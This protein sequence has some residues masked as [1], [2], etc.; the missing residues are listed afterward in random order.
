MRAG[1]ASPPTTGPP[2]VSPCRSSPRKCST[3]A[4]PSSRRRCPPSTSTCSS[5]CS[6]SYGY[7]MEVLDNDNR[8][9]IDMGLKYVN[10]DA[11]YPLHHRRRPDHG[12]PFC[13]GSTTRIS[14]PSIMTQ[15]GG[16]C[17]ASNY[18]AFIRR[19]LDKAGLWPHPGH[20]P[21]CQRHGEE[22]G[23]HASPGLLIDARC[24]RSSTATCFM[25]CLYRVRPYEKV[26]GSAERPARK[27]GGNRCIDSLVKQQEPVSV[28]QA[29]LPRDR[30]SISTRFPLDETL[31]KPR[32]GV[33]GEILVKYMPL[34]NNHL[35]DLL[36]ARGGGGR[37]AGPDGLSELLR[38]QRRLQA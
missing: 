36:E 25:R 13:P 15:T 5:R 2:A 4:I 29:R 20:L 34:A 30:G 17:R 18:V 31:R 1:A 37:R 11:C 32:V 7:H 14:S 12:A 23:L 38:L 16:C 9:A 26:P 27:S 3:R 33:V 28:L 24:G 10:N 8:S 21:Q 6:G 22:R 19:A 35:V